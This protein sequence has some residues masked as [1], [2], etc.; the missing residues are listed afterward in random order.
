M[1]YLTDVMVDLR[2]VMDQEEETS[3]WMKAYQ[4]EQNRKVARDTGYDTL[5]TSPAK[6]LEEDEEIGFLIE[7]T[8]GKR[9]RIPLE[10]MERYREKGPTTSGN[11]SESSK[12]SARK[13]KLPPGTDKKLKDIF[14]TDEEDEE[15]GTGDVKKKK[16]V[17]RALV[18]NDPVVIQP[19][20]ESTTPTGT[21]TPQHSAAFLAIVADI[22][23]ESIKQTLH[24]EES[25]SAGGQSGQKK[26]DVKPKIRPNP[27]TQE[28]HPSKGQKTLEQT[29]P[30]KIPLAERRRI[31]R[32]E[33]K[34]QEGKPKLVLVVEDEEDDEIAEIR[35]VEQTFEEEFEAEDPVE[36]KTDPPETHSTSFLTTTAEVHAPL[37]PDVGDP[38]GP[39]ADVEDFE[40]DDMAFPLSGVV[41]ER[42]VGDRSSQVASTWFGSID[43]VKSEDKDKDIK[44]DTS[45][46][47]VEIMKE[48]NVFRWDRGGVMEASKHCAQ[49]LSDPDKLCE[50]HKNILRSHVKSEPTPDTLLGTL[51][52]QINACALCKTT[53][54]TFCE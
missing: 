22:G 9:Y 44:S 26:E 24:Q 13:T 30:K 36:K 28:L 40:D 38:M 17:R 21:K 6:I 47:E 31:W 35:E 41:A 11:E 23:T 48:E 50:F 49:C 53:P 1:Y 19:Q 37:G 18:A 20:A 10:D 12:K 46:G 7:T 29:M 27:Y 15:D 33:L 3:S 25:P 8:P 16:N 14:S 2:D 32:E 42:S 51:M 39:D 52:S 5:S 54:G 34:K 4:E 43:K 45:S